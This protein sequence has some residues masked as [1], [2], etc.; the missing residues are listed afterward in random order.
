LLGHTV[1]SKSEINPAFC[2]MSAGGNSFASKYFKIKYLEC[3]YK[4]AVLKLV[5][6]WFSARRVDRMLLRVSSQSLQGNA[7]IVS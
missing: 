1:H 4:S 2:L 5:C 7:V 6:P 3:T